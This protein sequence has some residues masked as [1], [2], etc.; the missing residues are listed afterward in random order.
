MLIVAVDC[1]LLML[2]I[3]AVERLQ[4]GIKNLVMLLM[5]L[6]LLLL[7]LLFCC[8]VFVAVAVAVAFAVAVAAAN[9]FGAR[10]GRHVRFCFGHY[11]AVVRLLLCT[12]AVGHNHCKMT[13]ITNWFINNC[14]C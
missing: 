12:K 13:V 14:C 3:V 10:A 5:L 7:L 1:L 11:M 4:K 2:L 6:L 9:L 8:C